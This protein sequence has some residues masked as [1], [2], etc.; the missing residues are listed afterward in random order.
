MFILSSRS[1][2]GRGAVMGLCVHRDSGLKLQN[3]LLHVLTNM[4]QLFSHVTGHNLFLDGPLF[5]LLYF[6]EAPKAFFERIQLMQFYGERCEI[7][8]AV[9]NSSSLNNYLSIVK[10]ASLIH[11]CWK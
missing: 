7:V 5:S 1:T 10:A 6:L 8:E 9:P 2:G 11:A 3:K 4:R